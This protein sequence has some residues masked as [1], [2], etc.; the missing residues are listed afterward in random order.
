[1]ILVP[2]NHFGEPVAEHYDA[3]TADRYEPAVL[4]PTVDFLAELAGDRAALE[5]GIGTGRV[6]IPL[7]RRGVTVRGIDLSEAMVARLRAKPGAERI[8][9]TMGDFAHTRAPG[10]FGLAYLV[11]NTIGNLTSQ[12]EQVACFQ[13]VAEHLEPGGRF[14]IEVGVPDLRRLPPGETHRPFTVSPTH[15][16]FDEYDVAAQGLISHHYRFADGRGEVRSFPFRYVWPSELDL[17]AR[18]AGMSLRERWEDWHRRPFTGEST[19][20]VSVWQKPE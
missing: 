10:A 20:H 5:L 14:V 7:S 12:D 17:M 2:E 16:G 18:L 15:L 19:K 13:N 3:Q 9:V 4:D 11:Y 6:A 1:M 8:E